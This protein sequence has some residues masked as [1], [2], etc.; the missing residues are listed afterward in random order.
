MGGFP[1][2]VGAEYLPAAKIPLVMDWDP[3]PNAFPCDLWRA[4]CPKG[5][6]LTGWL[7]D[8]PKPEFDGA[9]NPE[10]D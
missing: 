8:V 7:D 3:P 6:G 9:P 2:D 1:A 5:F 10:L 4:C